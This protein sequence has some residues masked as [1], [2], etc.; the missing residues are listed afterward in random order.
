[1]RTSRSVLAGQQHKHDNGYAHE[2]NFKGTNTFSNGGETWMEVCNDV[3][4]ACVLKSL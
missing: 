4:P 3:L 1:M 2:N